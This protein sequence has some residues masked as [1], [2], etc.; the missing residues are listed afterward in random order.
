LPLFDKFG[1]PAAIVRP[2]SVCG[3]VTRK[4]GDQKPETC[5]FSLV[6]PESKRS[7]TCLENPRVGG[8]IPPQATKIS[9]KAILRGGFFVFSI[10]RSGPVRFGARLPIAL[11]PPSTLCRDGVDSP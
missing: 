7:L 11:S 10:D 1:A 4:T 2:S 5:L 3:S 8:S 6:Y 9:Q